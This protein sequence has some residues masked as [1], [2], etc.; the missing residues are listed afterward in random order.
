MA[1]CLQTNN[2]NRIPFPFK[3][4]TPCRRAQILY[5]H[6]NARVPLKIK[7]CRTLSKITDYFEQID[8]SEHSKLPSHMRK[9]LGRF[10]TPNILLRSRLFLGIWNVLRI[11]GPAWH[12]RFLTLSIEM[13]NCMQWVKDGALSLF[14]VAFPH[15][16]SHI[17][18]VKN[19]WIIYAGR[20]LSEENSDEKVK[21]TRHRSMSMTDAKHRRQTTARLFLPCGLRCK[22]AHT[23][24]TFFDY[25]TFCGSLKQ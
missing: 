12:E 24:K 4:G 6:G 3:N 14:V 15:S 18:I 2:K 9:K 8:I 11:F 5:V 1:V 23:W 17:T 7:I 20:V 13:L 21:S 19:E 22:Q 16:S 25:K 10:K